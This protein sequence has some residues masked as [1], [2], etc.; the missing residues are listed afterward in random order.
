L[1]AFVLEFWIDVA[2]EEFQ[3]M[4]KGPKVVIPPLINNNSFQI[5]M[6]VLDEDYQSNYI[7]FL[8]AAFKVF[9]WCHGSFQYH[10]QDSLLKNQY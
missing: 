2:Q 10:D 5:T 9:I 8:L 1:I 6:L 4:D 3:F 7:D